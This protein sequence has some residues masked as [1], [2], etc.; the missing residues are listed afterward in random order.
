MADITEVGQAL[1]AAIARAAYPGGTGQPSVGGCPILIYQGWP[2]P[3]QL[4]TDLRAGKVHVS[5]FPHPGDKVTSVMLGDTGWEELSNDGAQGISIREV[6]RQ[7][8]AFQITV[9]AGC[10]ASR[11]P[12]AAAIDSALAVITRLPLP[13]GTTAIMTYARSAQGDDQQKQGIY[14]RDLFYDVNYATVQT[15]THTTIREIGI[16]IGIVRVAAAAGPASPALG[17]VTTTALT[18]QGATIVI[19][20]ISP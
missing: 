19:K 7:T 16:G 12:V 11:D 14:R 17:P 15:A 20:E 10:F 9:W 6:R 8:R 5:V 1:V 2:N 13:E 4:E 18:A 3:Q